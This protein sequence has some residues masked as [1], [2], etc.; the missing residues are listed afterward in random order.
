MS[1]RWSA[2]F[3]V[4]MST[5]QSMQPTSFKLLFCAEFAHRAQ[6]PLNRFQL[7]FFVESVI[8]GGELTDLVQIGVGTLFPNATQP[9]DSSVWH[10]THCWRVAISLTDVGGL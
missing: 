5:W 3:F 9:G 2:F 10:F 6:V 8:F 7:R 1:L 4:L